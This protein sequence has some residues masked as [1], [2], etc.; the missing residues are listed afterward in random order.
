MG[1]LSKYGEWMKEGFTRIDACHVV[2]NVLEEQLQI[3]RGS[4]MYVAPIVIDALVDK[5]DG[6]VR[7]KAAHGALYVNGQQVTQVE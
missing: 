5:F 3:D 4:A 6:I 7:M 1:E 2:T